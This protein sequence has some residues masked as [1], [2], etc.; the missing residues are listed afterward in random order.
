MPELVD[1]ICSYYEPLRHKQIVFV[2]DATFVG[3]NYGVSKVD[4]HTVITECFK[5]HGWSVNEL[6]IGTPM[7]HAIKQQLINRMFL[8][9]GY[10]QILF[11]EPNNPD[12]LNSIDSAMTVNGTNQKDKSGEKVPETEENRLEGRTD[13]SDAFDTFASVSR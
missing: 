11:N 9:Q 10:Y 1:D 8:G 4:F 5:K 6:Y 7:N 12:L 3:N 2:Y 13:G